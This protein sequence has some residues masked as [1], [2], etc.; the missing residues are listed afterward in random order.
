MFIYGNGIS[1]IFTWC[2]K[3]NK[4]HTVRKLVVNHGFGMHRLRSTK[5]LDGATEGVTE[6]VYMY[7][8]SMKNVMNH[9]P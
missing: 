6:I 9:S 4:I 8:H 7:G 3:Q 2:N 1:F 5:S